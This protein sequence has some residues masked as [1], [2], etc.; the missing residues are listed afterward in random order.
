MLS[1]GHALPKTLVT[2]SWGYVCHN[3]LLLLASMLT[4][5]QEL[6]LLING[7]LTIASGL[8]LLDIEPCTYHQLLLLCFER[9]ITVF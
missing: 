3:L 7:F 4:S 9:C 2:Y 5:G 1:F 8:L 6:M